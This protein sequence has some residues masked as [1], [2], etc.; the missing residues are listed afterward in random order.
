MKKLISP[1]LTVLLVFC[2]SLVMAQPATNDQSAPPAQPAVAFP[3]TPTPAPTAVPLT[4]E[5]LDAHLVPTQFLGRTSDVVAI[6]YSGFRRSQIDPC[7]CVTNQLGGLDREA[8]LTGRIDELKIPN[9]KVDAGGFIRDMADATLVEQSKHLLKGM[10]RMGYQ[11]VNVAFTDLM[12]PPDQLEAT[13]SE[14]GLKL[15]SANIVNTS[16]EPVFAPYEVVD[17]TLTNGESLKVGVLGVTRPRIELT[18]A[19]DTPMPATSDGSLTITDPAAAMNKYLPELAEKSDFVVV[20]NYD[21]RSNGDR[22]VNS[23]QNRDLV[24]VVV[25]GENNQLQ[26]NAQAVDG[27]QVVSGGYEGR[28]LGTLYVELKDDNDI[29]SVWNKHIEIVQTIP[30][31]PEI[32][33]VMDAAHGATRPASDETSPG[34]PAPTKLD[35]GL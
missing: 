33:Q 1:A 24:D 8:R 35:L 5:K 11:V 34:A 27:V 9:I 28:Q 25:L 10:G 4:P 20:L 12:L 6:L 30:P 13:A 31:V 29:A 23:I 16:G 14:A 18:T 17:V 22:I 3:P 2:A 26:G 21:R 7:G 15:V 32:T 19:N